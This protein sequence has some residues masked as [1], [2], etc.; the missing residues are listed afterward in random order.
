MLDE[1]QKFIDDYH[2]VGWGIS[3]IV[4]AT[5]LTC[6]FKDVLGKW[7]YRKNKSLSSKPEKSVD[8]Y[9]LENTEE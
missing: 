5:I 2:I 3:L 7:R 9:R 1:M 6:F 8:M 4:I